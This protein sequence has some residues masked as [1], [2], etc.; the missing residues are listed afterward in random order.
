MGNRLILTPL[1]DDAQLMNEKILDRFVGAKKTFKSIDTVNDPPPS[2]ER[3]D[4]R[5]VVEDL[6]RNA[7]LQQMY[8]MEFLNSVTLTG[9]PPHKLNLKKAQ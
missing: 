7:L 1:N 2:G 6:N 4:Q 3:R 5:D 8:P 9:L